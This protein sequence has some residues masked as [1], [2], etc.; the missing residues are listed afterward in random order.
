M[1][2]TWIQLKTNCVRVCGEMTWLEGHYSVL[3]LLNLSVR[4]LATDKWTRFSPLTG[5]LNKK[6]SYILAEALR[7][8]VFISFKF[9]IKCWSRFA[10]GV[11]EFQ[12]P[13][14]LT[15]INQQDVSTTEY[16]K[17]TATSY[18]RPC[19]LLICSF[20]VIAWRRRPSMFLKYMLLLVMLF[21]ALPNN[22]DVWSREF[23]FSRTNYTQLHFCQVS[24]LHAYS[25][26]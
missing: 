8:R 5:D 16:W 1:D 18:L 7:E 20:K 26:V 21:T 3:N 15:S 24:H 13:Q 12:I 14:T 17:Q 22:M 25:T 11:A 19:E 2:W 10:D 9:Q 4:K 23:L 6:Q